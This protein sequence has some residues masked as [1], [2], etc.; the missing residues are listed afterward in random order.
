[1]KAHYPVEF[2]TA[3][4]NNNQGL[5]PKWVYIEEAKRSKISMRLPCVDGSDME[6]SVEDDAIRVGLGQIQGIGERTLESILD[7]R[8]FAGLSDLIARSSVRIA[9]AETLIRSGALDFTG[10]ARPALMLELHTSFEK[11]KRLRVREGLFRT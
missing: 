5:Y 6:F 9:E 10:L 3:A 11:A 1:M 7:T 4:L 2:W 8:P